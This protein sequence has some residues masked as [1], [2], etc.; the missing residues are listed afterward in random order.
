MT[1]LYSLLILNGAF[2]AFRI[3][4]LIKT[5]RVMIMSV[6][7]TS[8]ETEIEYG[9]PMLMVVERQMLPIGCEIW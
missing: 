4:L 5:S 8:S 2:I 1:T 6:M 9:T 3:S 7:R